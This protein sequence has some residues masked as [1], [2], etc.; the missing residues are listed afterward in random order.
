MP[1]AVK[2][3]RMIDQ[4]IYWL[5]IFSS[6]TRVSHKICNKWF[7]I[8]LSCPSA[9]TK[10]VGIVIFRKNNLFVCVVRLWEFKSIYYCRSLLYKQAVQKLQV[11][12]LTIT[13]LTCVF[14]VLK[15]EYS[16][17]IVLY[18]LNSLCLTRNVIL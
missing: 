2:G 15:I 12:F 5:P 7:C 13:K 8:L 16:G 17:Q 14:D 9:V 3:P 1:T 18:Y 11:T 10:P 4:L 6:N